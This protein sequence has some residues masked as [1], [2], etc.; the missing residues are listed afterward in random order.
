MVSDYLFVR[1]A[2]VSFSRLNE[3]ATH[4]T[5]GIQ[6]KIE[7]EF[8]KL[9]NLKARIV[10]T[11]FV[12]CG[13]E[14]E[15]QI[16]KKIVEAK[17]NV[18][19]LRAVY[20][21][22]EWYTEEEKELFILWNTTLNRWK[23]LK[24]LIETVF[25]AEASQ[26][27]RRLIQLINDN[28]FLTGLMFSQPRLYS[29]II[30]IIQTDGA[31]LGK[32]ERAV[33]AYFYRSA[34]KPSAF[35][36]FAVTAV[37][38]MV[39]DDSGFISGVEKEYVYNLNV[40]IF[41]KMASSL[42]K[43]REYI[44][45]SYVQLNQSLISTYEGLFFISKEKENGSFKEKYLAID[46]NKFLKLLMVY[47][48]REVVKFTEL[49][50]QLNEL[51]KNSSIESIQD[52]LLALVDRGLLGLDFSHFNK[53]KGISL[54]NLA[55]DT[56][57]SKELLQKIDENIYELTENQIY[58]VQTIYNRLEK[59]EFLLVSANNLSGKL[60]ESIPRNILHHNVYYKSIINFD[61]NKVQNI[62]PDIDVLLPI[63]PLFNNNSLHHDSIQ[64]FLNANG[65][66]WNVNNSIFEIFTAF[67]EAVK[68][69]KKLVYDGKYSINEYQVKKGS[70]LQRLR[71]KFVIGMFEHHS[72]PV[73]LDLYM[74][75]W[76]RVA[77]KFSTNLVSDGACFSGQFFGDA[78]N[79]QFVLN[80]VM[81]GYGA[82]FSNATF[83]GMNESRSNWLVHSISRQLERLSENFELVEVV[84]NFDFNGQLR[85]QITNRC[86]IYPGE[87]LPGDDCN[88]IPW[89]DVGL[90]FS[91]ELDKYV[92][93]DKKHQKNIL[94]VHLG[95]LASIYLPE[96]YKFII[97]LGVSFFP[98]FSM[99]EYLENFHRKENKNS[100]LHYPRLK[101]G[102]IVL[103][104]ETWSIP[105]NQLPLLKVSD[106]EFTRCIKLRE[107]SESLHLPELVFVTPMKISDFLK[108][109]KK[110]DIRFHRA[111]KP[112]YWNRND[113]TSYKLLI[114]FL[115]SVGPYLYISEMLPEPG[116]VSDK[117]EDNI[118]A[119]EY[120]FE[121]YNID[122]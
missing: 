63:L 47:P 73:R 88:I 76:G 87:N 18:Y 36:S 15:E 81:P 72:D 70:L 91:A 5:M 20:D 55:P 8:Q 61:Q 80:K 42:K 94:P 121:V 113:F 96:F 116:M 120:L 13:G 67:M 114:R 98:D 25:S 92:L 71:E 95:T 24:G 103:L 110:D 10:E 84:G 65:G 54:V 60:I 49:V 30:K 62:K 9:L 82:V 19:N 7:F 68:S 6:K 90:V 35:S 99:I 74:K 79:N 34:T 28:D 29:K 12:K 27:Q 32:N 4:E 104:R 66:K 46:E 69:D 11:L 122:D 14:Y 101:L 41:N 102:S 77:R 89:D 2:C 106:S 40:S 52:H 3:L 56:S 48:G 37:G 86:L 44:L 53:K 21:V 33:L 93:R 64:L 75:K 78:N 117:F 85:K 1:V 105:S 58:D 26:I 111:H 31:K 50:K 45:Q 107:W 100:V 51:Y 118:H 108:R 97:S 43:N 38:R 83:G 23:E 59:I 22:S 112:F 115:D 109:E 57:V 16:K 39:S 17:R 119:V